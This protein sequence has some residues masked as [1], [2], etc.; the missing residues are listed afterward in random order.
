M[1][2]QSENNR[3]YERYNITLNAEVKS[4]D[5]RAN[6]LS[7]ITVLKDISGGGARFVTTH[8]NYYG[9]GQ[10]V[11]LIIQ[12]PGGDTMN[13]RMEGVGRVIW[14]GEMGEEEV[15]VGL[16]MDDLLVFEHI[17]DGND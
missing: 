8:P 3:E 17:F 10:K 4:I 9:I 11:D 14:M 12:L 2:D 7:E 15:S 16:C 1:S 6:N 5:N 13:T